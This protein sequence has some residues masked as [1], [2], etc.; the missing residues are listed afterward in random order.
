VLFARTLDLGLWK[1][2]VKWCIWRTDFYGAEP[3]T[4]RKIEIPGNVVK[5][6]VDE[7]WRRSV[8]PIMGKMNMYHVESMKIGLS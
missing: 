6:G 8:V 5:S 3:W 2:L 4:F 1:K 7:G